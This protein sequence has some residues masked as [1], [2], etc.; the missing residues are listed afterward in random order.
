MTN[1]TF[2]I[3]KAIFY[4]DD[5]SNVK[6]DLKANGAIHLSTLIRETSYA[7]VENCYDLYTPCHVGEWIRYN[8]EL[9]DTEINVYKELLNE[10]AEY[11]I[12]DVEPYSDKEINSYTHVSDVSFDDRIRQI[13]TV[14]LME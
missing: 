3:K 1:V 9:Y 14:C 10:C 12:I 6:K 2:N 11:I 7:L 13:Y 4:G 8:P 5:L